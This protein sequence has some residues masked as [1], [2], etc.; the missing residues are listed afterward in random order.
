VTRLLT[1]HAYL[2]GDLKPTPRQQPQPAQPDAASAEVAAGAAT[3]GA[4]MDVDAADGGGSPAAA[5]KP[6]PPPKAKPLEPVSRCGGP[7]CHAA[8]A[9]ALISHYL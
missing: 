6:E 3:D 9:S 4:A 1:L 7:Q 8:A 2:N 5:A